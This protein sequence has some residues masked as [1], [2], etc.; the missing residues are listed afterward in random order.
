MDEIIAG[1]VVAA[2]IVFLIWL[3]DAMGQRCTER[4]M[5]TGRLVCELVDKRVV[6]KNPKEQSKAR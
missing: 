3:G 1:V 2:I 6:C 5:A 4:R